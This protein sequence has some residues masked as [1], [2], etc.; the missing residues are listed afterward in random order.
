MFLLNSDF[1][2]MD[3]E[4]IKVNNK[5]TPYLICAYNGTDYISSYADKSLNQTLLFTSFINQLF[6]FFTNNSK[7]ITVYAHNLSKF[8]G[9]FLFNQLLEF[10]KVKPR[11]HNQKLISLKLKL[12]IPGYKNKTIIFKDS[13]LML[14]G[15]LRALC[16]SFD[17]KSIKSY[18]PFNLSNIFYTGVLP[19]F[20]YWT[21]ISLSEYELF[22]ER[23]TGVEWNFKEEALKYCKLD[24]QS[25]HE[26]LI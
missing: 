9:V 17:V 5:L 16:S 25:L 21:G 8:D 24:C 20:E 2:T 10:G 11:Y 6:T 4:T 7:T 15:S 26:I 1:V 13:M 3:I 18:F 22:L 12:N 19:K 23:Y 14:P